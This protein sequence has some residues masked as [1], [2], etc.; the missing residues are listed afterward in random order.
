MD[1]RKFSSDHFFKYLLL[2]LVLLYTSIKPESLSMNSG[3]TIFS[4]EKTTSNGDVIS[5]PGFNL[6]DSYKTDIPKTILAALV[7]NGMYKNPYFGSNLD[8]IPVEQFQHPWWYRKEFN[9]TEVNR[10]IHYQLTFEGVNYKADLWLNGKKTEGKDKIEGPF[11]IFTFDVTD[12]LIKGKNII[13]VEVFPPERGDL[14]IGFVDWN[15]ASPDKN[16]GLWRGIKLKK[17]NAVSLDEVFIQSKV[18]IKTLKE[19]EITISGQLTNFSNEKINVEV[20]G[21]FDRDKQFSKSFLLE[22]G[23]K[24]E[25][26]IT[27]LD[28]GCLKVSNPRLWWPNNLGEPYLYNLKIEASV[29]GHISDKHD[30]RFGIREIEDYIN[31]NGYRGFKINGQKILIKGAGWVDDLMLNDSDEKVVDEIEYAKQ[32]NLNAIRLEGFW[33]KNETLYNA[34]DE[35]GILIMVGWSCQWDWKNL[36]GREESKYSCVATKK[37]VELQSWAF[38]QQVK[39]LRNHPSIFVWMLGSDK[40][41]NPELMQKMTS[42]LDKTD[43]TR[44]RLISAKGI[45]I[46]KDENINNI[47]EEPRV[48]MLGP[49]SYEPPVYWYADTAFGGAYGFNTETGPG[50][51]VPPLESLQRMLPDEDLWP[52]D[53]M[54]DYHCGRGKFH[55]LDEFI[56]SIDIRYGQSSS[57]SEFAAKCQISNYEAMRPMFEAFSVNKYNS[58]GVIQWMFNSAWPEMYWQL[59]DYY[60][61]PNGAFYGAMK[62]CQPLNIIYNY[63]DKN[64]YAANDYLKDFNDIKALVKIL[65]RNSKIIFEKKKE[66]S[67]KRNS[68]EKI[69]DLPE[70][71]NNSDLYFIYLEMK[72]NS[73][74]FICDNFYWISAKQEEMDFKNSNWYF[75]PIESYADFKSLNNLPDAGITYKEKHT[76]KGDRQNIEVTLEN[77]SDKIAFFIEL[78][79][80]DKNTGQSILP[81]FWDDNYVSLLPH[82]TKTVKGSYSVKPG[83][84][85]EEL[86]VNGWNIIKTNKE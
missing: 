49:Y 81:V 65:D 7:E 36:C 71:K 10:N 15:P 66:I 39:W 2:L 86:L 41:P 72:D 19:A 27:P 32:M 58:T 80:L 59:F 79:L 56:K 1:F 21:S 18:N 17:T 51:Q 28:A 82:S 20:H 9:I 77:T 30:V 43:P 68:S 53:S 40:Y 13:A 34:A 46:S 23:E 67:I 78:N 45:K 47:Y 64:I 29:G 38:N 5:K 44:P 25:F 48:K 60:L 31:E 11:G 54:W 55:N 35:N 57:V 33:G 69:I 22:A 73:G 76:Q 14:T 83:I 85:K 37:D 63:K 52:V 75:T 6:K 8:K 26:S 74:K 84:E 50:P 16:M 24:H 61:M 42:Y 4:S 3:W 12:Y 62:G 70:V